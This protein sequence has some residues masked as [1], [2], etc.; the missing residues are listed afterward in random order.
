MYGAIHILR[1]FYFIENTFCCIVSFGGVVDDYGNYA[2]L[3]NLYYIYI[4]IIQIHI[5]THTQLMPT[6]SLAE[7]RI[8]PVVFV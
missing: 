5:H 4:Y 6:S 8:I 2:W 7:N 3:Y 1:V